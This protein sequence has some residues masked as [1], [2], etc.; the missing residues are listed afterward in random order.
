MKSTT[1]V[2]DKNTQIFTYDQITCA[3]QELS[4]ELGDIQQLTTN[5]LSDPTRAV[6]G[7]QAAYTRRWSSPLKNVLYQRMFQSVITAESVSPLGGGSCLSA[8][9]RKLQNPRDR[10]TS[11]VPQ[12]GVLKAFYGLSTRDVLDT[13]CERHS[14]PRS[15]ADM[16]L[17]CITIAGYSG[18]VMSRDDVNVVRD[19]LQLRD[20]YT[21]PLQRLVGDPGKTFASPR[22]F[23]AD[24]YIESVSEIDTILQEANMTGEPLVIFLRG[25][26]D[27]LVS[28]LTVNNRRGT[29]K[30]AV[31]RVPFDLLGANTLT[32]IAVV[33]GGDPLSSL[34]GDL[35][36]TKHLEDLP[37]AQK[38]EIGDNTVVIY[39]DTT[40]VQVRRHRD[41]LITKMNSV[42]PGTEMF[43][44]S[45]VSMLSPRSVIARW[46]DDIT[47]TQRRAW[48]DIGIRCHTAV[49]SGGVI[50]LSDGSALPRLT[51]IAGESEAQNFMNW[52][53]QLGAVILKPRDDEEPGEKRLSQFVLI[54]NTRSDKSAN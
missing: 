3:L 48:F 26:S 21:L 1:G 16:C 40:T 11:V 25:C 52:A 32:D 41:T 30:T 51:S 43:I 31:Y 15:I 29:L 17:E 54:N 18:R 7:L 4:S 47:V 37:V 20:G 14:M 10:E 24:A 36:S 42:M 53:G 22:I 27:D 28:T 49:I 44:E 13:L 6:N 46:R 35:L 19:S 5:L 23:I 33:A 8:L 38:V 45:R 39:N 9:A 12:N 34:K 50:R 2:E